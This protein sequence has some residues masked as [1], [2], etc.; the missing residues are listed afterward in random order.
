MYATRPV[1][2]AMGRVSFSVRGYEVPPELSEPSGTPGCFRLKLEL[3]LMIWPSK[4]SVLGFLRVNQGRLHMR[5]EDAI[6]TIWISKVVNWHLE[7]NTL[8]WDY[9]CAPI[10]NQH[11][12]A[13]WRPNREKYSRSDGSP[14]QGSSL[15]MMKMQITPQG[16]GAQ[17]HNLLPC[18]FRI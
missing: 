8:I 12:S 3:L 6:G 18:W 2:W 13:L 9:H 14:H 17:T 10:L 7:Y 4:Q 16:I 11:Y 5:S 1:A 15:G